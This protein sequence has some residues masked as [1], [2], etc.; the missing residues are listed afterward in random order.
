V[1]TV[2][3]D[4]RGGPTVAA[5]RCPAGHVGP[6]G[7]LLCRVCRTQVPAQAP[8]QIPLPLPGLLR[9]PGGETIQLDRGVILGRAPGMPD[10]ADPA[11]PHHVKLASPH[12]DVS[13]RHVEIRLE[14]WDVVAVDL[15]SR[16]GTVV[17]QP[18]EHPVGL[19]HGGRQVLLPGAL[20]VLTD[21]VSF[22][23]EVPA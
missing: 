15:G 7:S 8:V 22:R 10:P 16:N 3:R 1:D 19:P 23:Y 18:G 13:R 14:G 21:E 9:L 6:P 20:V 17:R 11:R 2:F 4:R 5:V 12:N